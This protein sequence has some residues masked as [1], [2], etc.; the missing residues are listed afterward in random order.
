MSAASTGPAAPRSTPHAKPGGL[1][2]FDLNQLRAPE[3]ERARLK[4]L[5]ADAIPDDA[6]LTDLVA[7]HWRRSLCPGRALLLA[8]AAH[9]TGERWA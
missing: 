8:L 5:D 2:V 9:A 6:T 1:P 3:E 7:T 4:P